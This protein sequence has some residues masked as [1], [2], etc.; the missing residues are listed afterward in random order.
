MTSLDKLRLAAQWAQD[1]ING[2]MIEQN[3]GGL[4]YNRTYLGF[5]RITQW[6]LDFICAGINNLLLGMKQ[7]AR[8]DNVAGEIRWV[9]P[10]DDQGGQAAYDRSVSFHRRRLRK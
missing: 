9:T 2:D 4:N 10:T 1:Q 6:E 8:L 7:K 3:S 5:P